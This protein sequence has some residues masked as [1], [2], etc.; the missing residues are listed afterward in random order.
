[1]PLWWRQI[2]GR[3]AHGFENPGFSVRTGDDIARRNIGDER[4]LP[5]VGA[6]GCCEVSSKIFFAA[7]HAQVFARTRLDL[8]RVCSKKR[9]G[10]RDD[11]VAGKSEIQRKMMSFHTPP[12]GR[13][14]RGLAKDRDEIEVG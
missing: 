11:P 2:R 6:E 12:P 9:W 13:L 10:Y 4:D 14:A 7:Q 1:M 8:G 5:L 3:D